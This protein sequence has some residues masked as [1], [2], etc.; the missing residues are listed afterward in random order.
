V[1]RIQARAVERDGEQG[2]GGC[3]SRMG[4]RA[5]GSVDG[6]Q[7]SGLSWWKST[8]RDGTTVEMACL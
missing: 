7:L 6:L 3:G 8:A 5:A 4:F 2:D 1:V